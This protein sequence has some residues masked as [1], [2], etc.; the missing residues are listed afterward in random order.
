[1]RSGLRTALN[2]IYITTG[3]GRGGGAGGLHVQYGADPGREPVQPGVDPREL[4]GTA[5]AV[6][7][8]PNLSKSC[9]LLHKERPSRVPL[10]TVLAWPASAERHVVVIE[11][12]QVAIISSR[13]PGREI[14][15]GLEGCDLVSA[16]P[17]ISTLSSASWRKQLSLC[18]LLAGL[19]G[20]WEKTPP[21]P[22]TR[23][24][25]SPSMVSLSG[26]KTGCTVGLSSSPEDNLRR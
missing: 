6:A 13:G 10:A 8:N 1:M 24:V 22:V 23:A 12:D 4:C 19:S 25:L 5:V 11:G 21:Q 17:G 7:H 18:G 15:E 9:R 2:I 14:L 3:A 16:Y 26:S 20:S